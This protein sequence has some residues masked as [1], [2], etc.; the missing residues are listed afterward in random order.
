MRVEATLSAKETN[1]MSNRKYFGT[2]GIRGREA[3]C[4]GHPDFVLKL[5]W[6]AGKCWRVM[7]RVKIIIGKKMR[8]FQAICWSPRWRRTL[9]LR[10]CRP[11]LPDLANASRRLS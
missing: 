6:A 11:R 10:D 1:A 3:K 7:V 4:L 8:V 9:P 5:G 2:D